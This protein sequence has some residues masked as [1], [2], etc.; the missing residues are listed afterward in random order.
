MA[1]LIGHIAVKGS[2]ITVKDERQKILV[3]LPHGQVQQPV[4]RMPQQLALAVAADRF[5]FVGGD[6]EDKAQPVLAVWSKTCPVDGPAQLHGCADETAFFL[7][8]P[9]HA[10]ENIFAC[11][12]FAAQTVIF[13]EMLVALA[14]NAVDQQ[15]FPA[16]GRKNVAKGSD[17]GCV[18]VVFV[19]PELHKGWTAPA[20]DSVDFG[21]SDPADCGRSLRLHFLIPSPLFPVWHAEH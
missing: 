5:S 9:G 2:G 12:H 15:G 6:Q 1:A 10:G 11:F 18:H 16:R 17:N 7:D 8:F 4:H 13:S 14:G 19:F 21:C 20:K 3:A